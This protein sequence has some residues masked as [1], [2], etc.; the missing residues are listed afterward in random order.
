MV[1]LR[2]VE[3]EIVILANNPNFDLASDS[4][5]TYLEDKS[6]NLLTAFIMFLNAALIYFLREFFG[7]KSRIH[8]LLTTELILCLVNLSKT[9][10]S[11]SQ[12]YQN[13][14]DRLDMALRDY[15]H[16]IL[17]LTA[18]LVAGMV[19]VFN[20]SILICR[21]E[22]QPRLHSQNETK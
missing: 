8:A 18:R 7:N 15:D 21:Y 5:R 13:S 3:S 16:A 10:L 20:A 1:Y 2:R 14:K 9:A 22:K 17:Q 19:F 6:T 4:I 11:G 12:G